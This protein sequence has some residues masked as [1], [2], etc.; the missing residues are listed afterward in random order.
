MFYNVAR[1]GRMHT[2][3]IIKPDAVRRKLVGHIISEIETH[4][5]AIT[6]IRILRLTSEQA[7]G[8]YEMHHGKPFYDDLISYMTSGRSFVLLLEKPDAV[9]FW[10]R[11]MGATDPAQAGAETIRGR[12]GLTLLQN[13]VHGSDSGP[14]AAREIGFFFGDKP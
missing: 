11:L 6:A 4:D 7:A 12:F 10:R 1:N 2:L 5:F 14:S 8:F 13:T 3:A 9:E